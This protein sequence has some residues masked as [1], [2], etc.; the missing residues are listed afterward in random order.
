MALTNFPNGLS[1][2]GMPVV[3]GGLPIAEQYFF[4]NSVRGSNGQDGLS[5]ETPFGT[6]DFAV[7]KCQASRG[8][9]IVALPGHVETV[10]AAGGLALDVAG[11]N[12]VGVGVG[13]LRPRINF[14]TATTASMLVTAA[15]ISMTGFRF[16]GNVDALV[17]PIHVQAADFQL[18]QGSWTD[19]G[20]TQA[21]DVILTTAAADRL[22][23]DQWSHF[24]AA[25]AGGAAGIAL[26]GGDGIILSNIYADGN[27]S[28]GFFDVRTTAT[29]NLRAFNWMARTRN[30][31]DVIG[32]DTITGSTGIIG[33]NMFFNVADNAANFATAFSGA[34]FRYHNP[35]SVV[36][37]AG[38]IGGI[39][40]TA[41][42]GFKTQST[43]A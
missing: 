43:N 30:S 6:L 25:A 1:S 19:E 11:I 18:T 17:N 3:G 22:V 15:N 12:L 10:V 40:T 35:V 38:E 21:T 42:L 24:G 2:F 36:N 9:C 34:T 27:F 26:V 13:S 28:V 5:P 39:D 14:T 8:A 41:Q 32:V 16:T 29:T 4:V 7:A 37:L 33:P 23:V 20:S 31:A